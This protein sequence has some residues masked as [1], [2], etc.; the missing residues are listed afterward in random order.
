MTNF[1]NA[2]KNRPGSL[3]VNNWG[4]EPISSFQTKINTNAANTVRSTDHLYKVMKQHDLQLAII[5]RVRE[6]TENQ[7]M[8][9]RHIESLA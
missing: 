9:F 4:L 8:M 6:S 5:G 3:N 7:G 2:V 1:K